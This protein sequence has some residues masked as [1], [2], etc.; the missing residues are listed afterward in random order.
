MTMQ[1][2]LPSANSTLHY[3]TFGKVTS[4]MT[5]QDN[6]PSANSTLH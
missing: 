3:T 1:H 6:L 2:N 5:M 4:T